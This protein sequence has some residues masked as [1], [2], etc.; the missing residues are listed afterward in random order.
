MVKIATK[1][2][3]TSRKI[4]AKISA[5][6]LIK[7]FYLLKDIS[8]AQK[9]LNCIL[10]SIACHNL[11]IHSEIKRN[12]VRKCWNIRPFI[13]QSA[14]WTEFFIDILGNLVLFYMEKHV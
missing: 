12:G 2:S 4:K 11:S 3:Y 9:K 5:V 10:F 1:K 7:V 8:V 14:F 6:F 13:N